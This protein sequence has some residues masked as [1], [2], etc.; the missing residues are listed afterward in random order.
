MALEHEADV[1]AAESR[2]CSL[3][4][5][6]QVDAAPAQLA[7]SGRIEATH[8]IEQRGPAAAGGSQ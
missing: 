5:T 7:G 6:G 2:Q 3:I 4:G 1:P 8:D